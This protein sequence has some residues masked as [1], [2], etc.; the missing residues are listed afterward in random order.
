M[1]PGRREAVHAVGG[2]CTVLKRAVIPASSKRRTRRLA[3]VSRRSRRA[4]RAVIQSEVS[5]ERPPETVFR[6]LIDPGLQILWS[7]VPM[8]QLTTG[9]LEPGSQLEVTFS[10]GP[11]KARIGL[12]LST[13]EPGR[14]LAFKS[15]SGPIRWDGEYRL[16]STDDG[17]TLVSQE[18]RLAFS[19]AWRLT[20]PLVGAEISRSEIKEL[21]RLKT[22]VEQHPRRTSSRRRYPSAAC[23]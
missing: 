21:E 12:V 13:V 1:L 2:G 5:I 6:Y 20:E 18:G 4:C 19:G 17:A 15:F 23:W 9:D 22:V 8:R 14:V 7:A 16:A 10:I 11:L 3:A